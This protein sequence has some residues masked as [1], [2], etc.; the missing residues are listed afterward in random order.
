MEI[1]DDLIPCQV[2]QLHSSVP[3]PLL[4][5]SDFGWC[6]IDRPF[7]SSVARFGNLRGITDRCFLRYYSIPDW[8]WAIVTMGCWWSDS[9]SWVCP[10]TRTSEKTVEIRLGGSGPGIWLI[11][12]HGFWSLQFSDFVIVWQG[13]DSTGRMGELRREPITAIYARKS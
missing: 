7:P 3:F 2:I 6:S 1:I 10:P 13:R 4:I 5:H 9:M 11:G 8:H 12:H